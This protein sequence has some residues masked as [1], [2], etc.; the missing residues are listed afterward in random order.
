MR[1]QALRHIA[2]LVVVALVLLGEGSPGYAASTS[3]APT[4]VPSQAAAVRYDGETIFRGLAFGQGPVARLFPEL[5][6]TPPLSA[7]GTQVVDAIIA[8]MRGIDSTFFDRFAAEMYGSRVRVRAAIESANE[9]AKSAI[10]AINARYSSA[11]TSS[12]QGDCILVLVIALVVLA[13]VGGVILAVVAAGAVVAVAAV[14]WFWVWFWAPTAA[15]AQQA[16]LARDV[17]TDKIA[18]AMRAP[19][20]KAASLQ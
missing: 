7:E 8:E 5:A 9:L 16:S 11:S 3:G 12:E 19:S 10:L 6:A 18:R 2:W 14:A 20:L 4:G 13:V 1:P 17:W 15:A